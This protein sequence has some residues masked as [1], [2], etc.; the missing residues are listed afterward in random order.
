VASRWPIYQPA[1]RI[2]ARPP[3]ICYNLGT[4]RTQKG[5]SIIPPISAAG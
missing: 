3:E 1:D 4:D 5:A 2:V